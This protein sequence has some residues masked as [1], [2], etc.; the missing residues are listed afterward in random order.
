MEL[1]KLARQLGAAIQK[2]ETFLKFEEARKANE[3]DDALNALMGK[4]RLIQMSYQ[5]EASAETPDEGKLEAYNQE[6][7]GIYTEIMANKN[8][9]AYEESRKAVDDMMN[10]L[11]G[12][13]AMCVNG[14]DPETCDPKAH[15]HSECGGECSSCGGGCSH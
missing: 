3:A 10:Y 5:N 13:L 14:E 9:Q 7:Q 11:T 6:F 2:D 8:M 12:I 4:V 1:E 15:D